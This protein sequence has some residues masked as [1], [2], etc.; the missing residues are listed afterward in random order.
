LDCAQYAPESPFHEEQLLYIFQRVVAQVGNLAH[1][2]DPAGSAHY[3]HYYRILELLAHV[4]MGVVLVELGRALDDNVELSEDPIQL[5]AQLFHTLLHMLH[6]DHSTQIHEMVQ[7]AIVACLDE[8]H[9]HVPV[10]LLDELLLCLAPGPTVWAIN[11]AAHQ[12][13]KQRQQH[14]K[15]P[16]PPN[17]SAKKATGGG[18]LK[19]P[20]QIEQPNPSYHVAAKILRATENHLS[21]SVTHL[22]VGLLNRE[23]HY[24]NKSSIDSSLK[25]TSSRGNGGGAAL[26][27]PSSLG[28]MSTTQPFSPA[29]ASTSTSSPSSQSWSTLA[30]IIYELH[31]VAPRFLTSV[32]GTVSSGLVSHDDSHRGTVVDLLG[33]VFAAPHMTRPFKTCYREWLE[34]S[35]DVNLPIRRAMVKHLCKI[36]PHPHSELVDDANRALVAMLADP[37]L[38]IRQ[39]A[40]YEVTDA[41]Y[42]KN[43]AP[44]T[45]SMAVAP[46]LLG[47]VA[48]RISSK[49]SEE[50]RYAITGLAQVYYRHYVQDRLQPIQNSSSTSSSTSHGAD[51][52][53][54]LSTLH[55]NC[56][57]LGGAAG[58]H[59][60]AH[61]SGSKRRKHGPAA[62]SAA[63]SS[64]AGGTDPDVFRIIP[65]KIFEAVC[66]KDSVDHETRSRVVQ[67]VDEVLL[68][69]E[70]SSKSHKRLTATA[71]AAGLVLILDSLVDSDDDDNDNDS[72]RRDAGWF[73]EGATAFK[74]VQ[75]LFGQRSALQAAL[76][77]YLDARAASRELEPGTS[78]FAPRSCPLIRAHFERVGT[79][80]LY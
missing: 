78:C 79:L 66:V 32:I 62:A 22:L 38:E 60:H 64:S 29:A 7:I 24:T 63:F 10:P 51:V 39:L 5:L 13:P 34:R 17:A 59:H 40:I 36:L 80:T 58:Q 35:Q 70:L 73:H 61:A 57:H 52:S 69:S 46:Q 77:Q 4:R 56:R 41:I 71:R 47:A 25:S 1:A 20:L 11:P 23:P 9:V 21:V 72:L 18:G 26:N 28:I 76:K 75:H 49:Y 30:N 68:G 16:P 42:R 15:Q 33:R 44:A 45:A 65:R 12:P 14:P 27:D 74:Y 2:V 8:Y 19:E 54:V 37:A 6:N 31:R 53:V 55:Q 3:A 50:R 48:S 43:L 67:V